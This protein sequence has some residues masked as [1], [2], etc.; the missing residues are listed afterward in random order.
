MC[1]KFFFIV[2]RESYYVKCD[3]LC[4]YLEHI[5]IKYFYVPDL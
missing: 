2:L 5:F 4:Y 3:S 1:D